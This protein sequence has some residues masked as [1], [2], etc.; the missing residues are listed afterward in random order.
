MAKEYIGK[1]FKCTCEG[2]ED[3]VGTV[4]YAWFESEGDWSILYLN[5]RGEDFKG[6]FNLSEGDIL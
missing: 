3:C 2:F 5:V 6:A 4:V 1:Q